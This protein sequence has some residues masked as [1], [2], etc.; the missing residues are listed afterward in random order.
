MADGRQGEAADQLRPHNLRTYLDILAAAGTAHGLADQEPVQ[1][2]HKLEAEYRRILIPF[3]K[4]QHLAKQ[5]TYNPQHILS[6]EDAN[7]PAHQ[8]EQSRELLTVEVG[9]VHHSNK[10]A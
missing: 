10:L 4:P 7:M 6:L 5:L 1:L 3:G 2:L 8:V 9:P